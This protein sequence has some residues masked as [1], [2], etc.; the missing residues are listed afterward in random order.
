MY[1]KSI[2][3]TPFVKRAEDTKNIKIPSLSS[4]AIEFSRLEVQNGI[5]QFE[6]IDY[7]I[8]NNDI[9]SLSDDFTSQDKL[10]LVI[11]Y[12]GIKDYSNLFPFIVDTKLRERIGCFYS[13]AEKTFA[14]ESWLSFTLMC[15]AIF[16][17]ILFSSY[18]DKDLLYKNNKNHTCFKSDK[19][20]VQFYELTKKA[21]ENEII[22]KE[23][24]E[25]INFVRTNRNLIHGD[26]FIDDY[27]T[28]EKA[29]E[30][31]STL[32]KTIWKF[33]ELSI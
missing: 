20:Q 4:Y 18:H 15:G 5:T 22:D 14:S 16:E 32:D 11:N 28:R 24:K 27:I 3:I 21:F 10:H 26:N 17:G 12:Y 9:L 19:K 30:I 23:T 6:G 29:Y 31:K 13:E 1:V 2:N 8:K 33:I 25:T 7:V